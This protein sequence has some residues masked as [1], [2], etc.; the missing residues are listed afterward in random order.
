LTE[1]SNKEDIIF[2]FTSGGA[3]SI[4]LMEILGLNVQ[5]TFDLQLSIANASIT[6][7]KNTSKGWK[8]ISF[9]N[10]SHFLGGDKHLL[11]YK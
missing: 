6:Q 10:H 3:I 8:L 11:T 2:I 5:H 1:N 9:N 7:I 4:A